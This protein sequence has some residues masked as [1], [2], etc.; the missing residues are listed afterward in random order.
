MVRRILAW[1][2]HRTPDVDTLVTYLVTD[3]C[4]VL[5]AALPSKDM[6]TQDRYELSEQLAHDAF[7]QG[8]KSVSPETIHAFFEETD[9]QNI[10]WKYLC[11]EQTPAIIRAV[12]VRLLESTKGR[13]ALGY[14]PDPRPVVARKGDAQPLP[15]VPPTRGTTPTGT[16]RRGYSRGVTGNH[17]GPMPTLL[18]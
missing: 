17:R 12:T 16:E 13:V 18:P 7:T 9:L 11:N 15:T 8:T 3:L 1:L 2:F 14:I 5:L 6:S 4:A 10:L